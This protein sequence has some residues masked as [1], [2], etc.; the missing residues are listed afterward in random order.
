MHSIRSVGVKNVVQ[1]RKMTCCC[2][3]CVTGVVQ[4]EFF[5]IARQWVFQS[6]TGETLSK[7]TINKAHRKIHNKVAVSDEQICV[8]KYK[9][10]KLGKPEKTREKNKPEDEEI[11]FPSEEISLT[12]YRKKKMEEG[13][14]KLPSEDGFKISQSYRKKSNLGMIWSTL[15]KTKKRQMSMIFLMR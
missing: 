13:K 7:S 4:C 12:M 9:M 10:G 1:T 11:D 6:V 5:K 2:L 14:R 3:N 15:Q 8:N